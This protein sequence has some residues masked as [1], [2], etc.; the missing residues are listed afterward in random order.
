MHMSLAVA[1]YEVYS[2]SIHYRQIKISV[3]RLGWAAPRRRPLSAS[4]FTEAEVTNY[5]IS[6]H[7]MKTVGLGA[8]V[9]GG[10]GGGVAKCKP[11]PSIS[12]KVTWTILRREAGEP[13]ISTRSTISYFAT[14]KS[15]CPFT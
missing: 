15:S 7:H 6:E 8:W 1:A 4:S 13:E 12:A 5:T 10:V 9:L 3:A 11:T 14:M 2:S